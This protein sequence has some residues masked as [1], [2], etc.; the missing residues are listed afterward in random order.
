MPL[1]WS[2]LVNVVGRCK[3]F[4]LT[5]HMRPDPDGLGSA[6]GLAGVLE[7]MG[8]RV[9]VVIAG[10]WPPRY[11]FLDPTRRVACVH[12]P[13]DEYR[14]ADAFIVLDTGT[15]N[16]LG[17][18]GTLLKSLTC[19]KLVIDHH[20]SQDDLG[21]TRLVDTSA[22]ATGRLV[23]EAAQA[24]RQPITPAIANLLFAAL[25]TDTGWFRHK[26]TIPAT[27]ALAEKL[28]AAGAEP[29]RL[30]EQL[31]EQSTLPRL[32]LQ[33]LALSRMQVVHGGR[34][35][36]CE[37]LRDDYAATGAIPS[38]TEELVNAPRSITG[39]QAAMVFMEQPAGGVKISFRSRDPIDVS[40]IAESFDGG[41]HRLAAGAILHTS[42]DEAKTRVLAAVAKA[43]G[44]TN[45]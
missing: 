22:E 5:T 33:G 37:I 10:V 34:T 43:L 36:F 39:V 31:Y 24:L 15:W 44:A 1:D 4:V 26:N 13:G 27:Y 18:V 17:D 14:D 7:G 35:A 30:Y 38:D 12:L 29:T 45:A 41:G 6:L 9:R 28:T 16:Q 21:A 32:K 3:N 2:P 25:A 40:K 11:D 8:K 42:M 23:F 20:L 19:T